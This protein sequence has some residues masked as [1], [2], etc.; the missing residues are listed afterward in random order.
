MSWKNIQDLQS[1]QFV[2]GYCTNRI[3]SQ[4][5][6]SDSHKQHAIYICPHCDKP[7]I[8]F[9][10][11]KRIPDEYPGNSVE[12]LPDNISN[13]Y[14]EARRSVSA[15]SYTAAVM[16]CR[17]LLMHIAVEKG[18]KENKS[19]KD[20]VDYLDGE[21]YLPPGS[22]NWVDHIRTQGNEANHEIIPKNKADAIELIEFIE[23]LTKFIYEFPARVSTFSPESDENKNS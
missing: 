3:A 22:K 2:C 12:G 16:L 20:Y 13:L 11:G 1:C 23:M 8:F 9:S 10:S 7:N 15:S 6:Y 4:Y 14:N 17:K 21:G 18:A 19:F 5:G